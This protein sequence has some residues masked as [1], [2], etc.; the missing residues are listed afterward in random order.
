MPL[1]ILDTDHISL[2]QRGH[3]RAGERF[4]ATP[5]NE[6]A[7]SIIT[8]G[9]QLRGRLAV[10]HR[11]ANTTQ[12]E[13]AYRRL[14]EMHTFFCHIRLLDFTEQAS[15]IYE[16]LRQQQRRLGTMDLRIAAITLSVEGILVTRN[17]RDFAVIP[18]LPAEDWSH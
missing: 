7:T 4:Y 11:P 6:L 15:V 3:P 12:L 5:E 14:R 9:E 17:R 10:V 16:T 13:I 1:F 18:N 2:I 8:Y